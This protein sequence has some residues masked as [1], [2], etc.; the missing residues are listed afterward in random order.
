M[1]RPLKYGSTYEMNC[2]QNSHAYIQIY[3]DR[4][5]NRVFSS[6]EVREGK[7]KYFTILSLE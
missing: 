4:N 7:I 6:K 3:P 1:L 5:I 2:F